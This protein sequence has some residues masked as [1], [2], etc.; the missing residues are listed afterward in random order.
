MSE[1]IKCQ[2]GSLPE[3]GA[4][5]LICFG[6]HQ[7]LAMA[8][9]CNVG[10]RP[11]LDAPT[12]SLEYDPDFWQPLP[13]P[14]KRESSFEAWWGKAMRGFGWHD[15]KALAECAWTAAIAASKRSDFVP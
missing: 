12:G 5:V 7:T 13:E 3:H 11:W 8:R 1:W 10:C 2:T 14:P 6:P 4:I 15:N 9:F